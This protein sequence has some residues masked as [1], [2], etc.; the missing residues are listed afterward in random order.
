MLWSQSTRHITRPACLG[1]AVLLVALLGCGKATPD[2]V[3]SQAAAAESKAAP[4]K[5]RERKDR[6]NARFTTSGTTWNGTRATARMKEG[7]LSISA[8]RM[9]RIDDKMQRDALKLSISDFKGPGRY[10]VNMGSMFVR[11]SIKI[12]KKEGEE[13]DAQKTLMDALGNTS[14]IRLANAD[15]EIVSVS[16]GYIDGTF[17]IEKPTGTPE[18][19][20]SDGQFHARIRE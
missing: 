8:S 9:D 2:A 12:P 6:G 10:K 18:S 19:T 14:N 5:S 3:D 1:L 7:R 11:V 4:A 17:S 16:D 13:V 15:V 20:I